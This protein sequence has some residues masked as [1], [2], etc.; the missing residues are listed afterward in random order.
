MN[1]LNNKNPLKFAVIN[2]CFIHVCNIFTNA[3][4]NTYTYYKY[5]H[6]YI[7]IYKGPFKQIQRLLQHAVNTLLNQMLGAFEQDI[8]HGF[9]K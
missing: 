1:Y 9:L 4:M 7:F 8:Q 3:I 2:Y 6:V 5:I